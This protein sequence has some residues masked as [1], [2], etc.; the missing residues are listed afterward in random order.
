MTSINSINLA[1]IIKADNNTNTKDGDICKTKDIIE[2]NS[3]IDSAKE[4]TDS[5]GTSERYLLYIG[6]ETRPAMPINL[7]RGQMLT[8]KGT[9]FNRHTTSFLRNDLSWNEF[10]DYLKEKFPNIEDVDINVFG[11]STGKEP[12]TL[13]LLLKKKYGDV[14]FVIK[15]SDISDNIIKR[16]KLNKKEGIVISVWD[17][18]KL[19][20]SLCID[21]DEAKKFFEAK[22]PS[23]IQ[24][25]DD[26]TD[27]VE[28]SKANILDSLD[29]I[30]SE[31]PS[32]IFCRNMWPYID[33]K[34]YE[35]FAQKL[36]DKLA[37]GSIVVIGEYD[38]VGEISRPDTDKFPHA[39][40]KSGF[41][42][43]YKAISTGLTEFIGQKN[44]PIIYEKN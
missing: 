21:A 7:E 1:N 19:K 41:N 29:K 20:N 16:N 17:F 11:C 22:G 10:G 13:S 37:P 25:K 6:E 27:H 34:E 4:T 40:K 32:L 8:I 28:F 15:A 30:N 31:K 3:N 44:T 5:N 9:L 36:Y 42:P 26:V 12:Y 33:S 24:I 18:D 39:L 2:E 14:P 23:V 38:I 35:N 43:I